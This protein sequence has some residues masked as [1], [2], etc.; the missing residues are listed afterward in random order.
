MRESI[1]ASCSRAALC[2]PRPRPTP[3][4]MKAHERVKIICR[5]K[6]ER[7]ALLTLNAPHLER[8]QRSTRPQ[9]P[10]NDTHLA[11]DHEPVVQLEALR[12]KDANISPQEHRDPA[13]GEE[14]D[15]GGNERRAIVLA[16]IKLLV[17]H[18]YSRLSR[19]VIAPVSLDR[20]PT[21]CCLSFLGGSLA[22]SHLTSPSVFT[23]DC[24]GE[25]RRTG[26]ADGRGGGRGM[27]I[28]S[29]RARAWRRSPGFASFGQAVHMGADKGVLPE[30]TRVTPHAWGIQGPKA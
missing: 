5:S 27:L 22:P 28:L 18:V 14:R 25:D 12:H 17:G 29:A 26:R 4:R 23:G 16:Q 2:R 11:N 10:G 20:W 24:D 6:S 30:I 3:R 19:D 7:M 13:Q 8:F 9:G 15:G 1:S 21:G